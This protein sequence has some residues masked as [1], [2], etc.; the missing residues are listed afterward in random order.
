MPGLKAWGRDDGARTYVVGCDEEHPDRGYSVSTKLRDGTV[1]EH[2]A[3][4]LPTLSRAK[5]VADDHAK[6][7]SQ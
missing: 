2:L 6:Q 5:R 3:T 1:V 7:H 4:R